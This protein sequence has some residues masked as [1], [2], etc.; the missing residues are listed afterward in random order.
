MM[1]LDCDCV[2]LDGGELVRPQ[3]APL[4]AAAAAAGPA[5][6]VKATLLCWPLLLLLLGRLVLK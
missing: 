6:K 2:V 5:L 1:R 3:G 4:A